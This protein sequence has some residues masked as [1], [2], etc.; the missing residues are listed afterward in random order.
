M[1]R[2][3]G[4]IVPPAFFVQRCFINQKILLATPHFYLPTK[5]KLIKLDVFN[6]FLYNT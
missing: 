6:E 4:G 2:K 5:D 3:A 1:K